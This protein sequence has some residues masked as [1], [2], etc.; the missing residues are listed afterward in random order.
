MKKN[1]KYQYSLEDI[2]DDGFDDFVFKVKTQDLVNF[3]TPGE[4]NQ[5]FVSGDLDG[6]SF[7]ATGAYLDVIG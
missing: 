1:G 4:E 7:A 2:N 5:L 6:D 3:L